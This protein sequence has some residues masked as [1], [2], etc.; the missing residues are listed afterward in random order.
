M[1]LCF[2]LFVCLPTCQSVYQSVY[3]CVSV[4]LPLSSSPCVCVFLFISLCV[5]LCVSIWVAPAS[6]LSL[7]NWWLIR[8]GCFRAD[9]HGNDLVLAPDYLDLATGGEKMTT[10]FGEVQNNAFPL[11]ST[12]SPV[13]LILIR[14][15]VFVLS[16]FSSFSS[17]LHWSRFCRHSSLH[18]VICLK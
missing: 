12:R 9:V 15:S 11:H 18:L 8:F 17:P 13:A 14:F 2:C 7:H 16:L 3:L 4:S 6:L 5:C 1:F 10:Q